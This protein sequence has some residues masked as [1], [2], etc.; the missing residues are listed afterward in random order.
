MDANSCKRFKL[1]ESLRSVDDKGSIHARKFLIPVYFK[2][3]QTRREF[4]LRKR[5]L[6]GAGSKNLYQGSGGCIDMKV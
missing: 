3:I 5:D 1:A 4:C 2:E 6:M